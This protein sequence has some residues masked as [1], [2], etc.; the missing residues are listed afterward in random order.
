VK[1]FKYKLEYPGFTDLTYN[2]VQIKQGAPYQFYWKDTLIG[3]IEKVDVKWEQTSG[4]QTLD[5]IVEGMGK[6]IDL[7]T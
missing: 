4:R 3:G 2:I 5:E 6:Y 1:N 7:H